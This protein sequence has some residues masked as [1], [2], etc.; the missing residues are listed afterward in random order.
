MVC[1]ITDAELASADKFEIAFA[2]R[3]VVAVLAS[4]KRAWVY[5]HV[6]G[7]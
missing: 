6:E 5:V 1:E 4:G 7:A 3:R 2:Y